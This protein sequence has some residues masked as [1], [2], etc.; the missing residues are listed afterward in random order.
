[1][2][3]IFQPLVSM[4]KEFRDSLLAPAEDPRG[5]YGVGYQAAQTNEDRKRRLEDRREQLAVGFKTIGCEMGLEALQDLAQAYAQL[6]PVLD[7]KRSTDTLSM[8]QLPGLVELAFNQGL[9]VLEDALELARA[10][11]LPD[12]AKLKT[13]VVR[14][15]HQIEAVKLGDEKDPRLAI[16][17]EK[18]A[19]LQEL[20]EMIRNQQLR[21]DELLHQSGRCQQSM[22]RTLIELAAF[23]AD[24]SESSV[25]T[26]TDTLRKTISQARGVQEE[27][28]RLGL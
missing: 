16:P 20:S 25:S 19:S 14:V 21:V 15:E 4:L 28:K 8:S 7:R 1:M 26:V 6:Q 23:R 9:S 10:I 17:E 2:A 27:L 3:N 22:Q 5:P 13:D 12:G 18:L 11:Q 24:T